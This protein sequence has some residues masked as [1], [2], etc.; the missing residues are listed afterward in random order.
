MYSISE[1]AQQAGV[2][3]YQIKYMLQRGVLKEPRRVGNR[4]AFT[5]DDVEAVRRHFQDRKDKRKGPDAGR[6]SRVGAKGSRWQQ[7]SRM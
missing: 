2:A 5:T 6:E 4:R 1:V 3:A 7:P